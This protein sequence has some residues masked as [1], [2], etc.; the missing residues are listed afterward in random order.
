MLIV[1]ASLISLPII[2]NA[3]L[4]ALISLFKVNKG[5]KEANRGGKESLKA[6]F[7]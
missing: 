7:F 3:F 6:I 2:Y 4:Y 5:F 1:L